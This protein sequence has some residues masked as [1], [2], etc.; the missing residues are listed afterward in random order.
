VIRSTFPLLLDTN[1]AISLLRGEL[2]ASAT[3]RGR[4]RGHR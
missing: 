2:K 1:A 3:R 4:P